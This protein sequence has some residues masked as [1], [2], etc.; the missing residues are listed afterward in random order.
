MTKASQKHLRQ[1]SNLSDSVCADSAWNE[2]AA[3]TMQVLSR[4]LSDHL[5]LL[6]F[7]LAG[8]CMFGSDGK[9]R[10]AVSQQKH[11]GTACCKLTG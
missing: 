7:A 2:S 9:V 11:S 3:S 10:A 8:G 6:C 5:Q 4:T 1:Q